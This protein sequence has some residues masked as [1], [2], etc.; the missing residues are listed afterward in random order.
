MTA[1]ASI[2]HLAAE[3]DLIPD[4]A[5]FST[6]ASGRPLRFFEILDS[7]RFMEQDTFAKYVPIQA[8]PQTS[9]YFDRLLLWIANA[10]LTP[11]DKPLLFEFAN[12][13]CYFSQDD[14]LALY[15]SAFTGPVS[16]WV[17]QQCAIRL[18]E[19][20]WESQF[21]R[22]RDERT[23]YCPVTDSMTIGEFYHINHLTGVSHRP[24]FR[25]LRE[26][27]TA[28]EALRQHM[29][30]AGMDRLVLLEDF[31]GTGS[32][33]AATVEWAVKQLERPVLFVPLIIAPDGMR[34]LLSLRG[35]FLDGLLS[36][37]PVIQLEAH[38]F[39][40]QATAE[41]DPLFAR[42]R[43]LAERVHDEVGGDSPRTPNRSPYSPMGFH[44]EGDTATGATVVLYSNC[45]NNTLPM[46]HHH[47]PQSNWKPLFPRV[48][49][50]P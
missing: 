14:F 8:S 24:G 36:I 23:W 46:V 50:E 25:S 11:E 40:G 4:L 6:T 12:R 20:G 26:F 15:R 16:R 28:G 19:P 18:D 29:D 35:K 47:S 42:V 44:R 38:E 31:V 30:D 1:P 9:E 21:A 5:A 34:R 17:A 45:P 43:A 10:G 27:Q 39:V 41:T 3:W 13:L 22:Q 32:Q 48:E 49:R 2:D 37:E 33:T 7:L